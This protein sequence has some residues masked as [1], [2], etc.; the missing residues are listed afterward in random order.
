MANKKEHGGRSL[1][2]ERGGGGERGEGLLGRVGRAGCNGGASARLMRGK[3]YG[4]LRRLTG[5]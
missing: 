4:M 2:R 5:A 3:T 1:G